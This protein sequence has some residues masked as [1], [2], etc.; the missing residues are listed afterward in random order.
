MSSSMSTLSLQELSQL[1]DLTFHGDG[2]TPIEG[3][4]SLSSPRPGHIVMVENKEILKRND[5]SMVAAI[6]HSSDLEI[7]V[8]GLVSSNLRSTLASIVR[9]FHPERR[10]EP[11]V[12]DTATIDPRAQIDPSATVGPFC[13]VGPRCQIGKE[14][15]LQAYVA[16]G[17]DSVI[18]DSCRL[19]AHAVVG[20]EC[21]LGNDCRLEPWAHI[22][23]KASLADGVDIGSHSSIGIE[24]NI[25]Q[26]AK[27]DNLV[28]VGPRCEIGA[29]TILVGQASVERDAILH[30][31]VVVAG[32]GAI[33]PEAEVC[34]GAQIGGRSLVVGKLDKPGPY[35]GNPAIPLKQEVRRRML[36]RKASQK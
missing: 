24:A 28:V 21:R 15:V 4:C 12:H 33:G 18:G 6:L 8:P 7:D 3:L 11:G 1:L 35:L 22:S 16:V 14:T 20:S 32:Q 23:S 26:G 5:L 27:I 36:E 29:L 9:H 13:V 2:S 17:E 25:G 34:S 31:G 19:A 10:P 30:P